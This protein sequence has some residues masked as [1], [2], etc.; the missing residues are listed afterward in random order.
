MIKKKGGRR[1]GQRAERLVEGFVCWLRARFL[2]RNRHL[3]A[4]QTTPV[5]REM[6]KRK[7][8]LKE[9]LFL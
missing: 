7:R 9:N 8:N 1:R 2:F 5:V 4:G 3:F 6:T